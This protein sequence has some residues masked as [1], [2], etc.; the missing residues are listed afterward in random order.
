LVTT[1]A[2]VGSLL[3]I[4]RRIRARRERTGVGVS[5]AI[6]D[7]SDTSSVIGRVL[8]YFEEPHPRMDG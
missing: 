6:A 1:S 7:C 4:A 5:W 8:A 3:V 2:T